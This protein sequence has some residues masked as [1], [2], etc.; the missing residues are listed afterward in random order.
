MLPLI[1]LRPSVLSTSGKPLHEFT[2]DRIFNLLVSIREYDNDTWRDV[3]QY[4]E[5]LKPFTDV[6]LQTLAEHINEKGLKQLVV[7]FLTQYPNKSYIAETNVYLN[8]TMQ[9]WTRRWEIPEFPYLNFGRQSDGSVVVDLWHTRRG[10]TGPA[11]F[12]DFKRGVATFFFGSKGE[13]YENLD[14]LQ[15]YVEEAEGGDDDTLYVKRGRFRFNPL[16]WFDDKSVSDLRRDTSKARV[17]AKL[18]NSHP[19]FANAAFD[20]MEED[21]TTWKKSL[22]YQTENMGGK[23]FAMALRLDN[24]CVDGDSETPLQGGFQGTLAVDVSG[25]AGA[26]LPP[27]GAS[28]ETKSVVV[29]NVPDCLLSEDSWEALHI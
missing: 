13:V 2:K 20:L 19:S 7:W 17:V 28:P 18:V 1:A 11:S 10:K 27:G 12:K 3:G 16:L 8:A 26:L 21:D 25:L 6:E 9:W 24:N 29:W 5:K 22:Y 4:A 23:K 15:E 14:S